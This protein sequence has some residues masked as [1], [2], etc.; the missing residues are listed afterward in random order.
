MHSY[1]DIYFG[2]LVGIT[3]LRTAYVHTSSR[4]LHPHLF[5]TIESQFLPHLI[6]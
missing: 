3:L 6:L 4:M 2:W 5:L 1:F